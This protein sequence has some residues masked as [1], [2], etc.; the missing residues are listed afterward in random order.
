MVIRDLLSMLHNYNLFIIIVFGKKK[1]KKKKVS[2]IVKITKNNLKI[3]PA[4]KLVDSNGVNCNNSE[5]VAQKVRTCYF[6]QKMSFF[7]F[8]SRKS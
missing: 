3:K 4:A 2:V 8:F 6:T 5:K 1:K 7:F